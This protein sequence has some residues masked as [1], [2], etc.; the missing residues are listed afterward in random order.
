MARLRLTPFFRPI[1][2]IRESPRFLLSPAYAQQQRLYAGSSYGGGEGDPKGSNPSDQGS[3]PSADL[4]HPGPPPPSVGQGTGG[5]PTKSGA[6]GHNT[7]QNDSSKSSD[8]ASTSGG[9]GGGASR[10]EGDGPQPKIH[11]PSALGEHTHSDE[12]RAHN[13]EMEKRHDRPNERSVDETD[14]VDKKY[15]SGRGGA[16]R[17]P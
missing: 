10:V 3:N 11:K 1:T 14:K 6:E 7:Q 13:E 5:G 9:S 12:V 2:T 4:E 17:N 8:Q 16:D 15:W